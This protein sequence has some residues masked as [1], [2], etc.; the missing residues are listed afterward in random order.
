M[1]EMAPYG[2][3]GQEGSG[4]LAKADSIAPGPSCGTVCQRIAS[5]RC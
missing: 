4:R 1:G 5:I 2:E 3:I